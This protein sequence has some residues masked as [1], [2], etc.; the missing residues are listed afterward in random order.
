VNTV[1]IPDDQDDILLQLG[2]DVQILIQESAALLAHLHVEDG[3]HH[4]FQLPYDL[5]GAK[6]YFLSRCLM[7]VQ[8][9]AGVLIR[10]TEHLHEEGER[11]DRTTP[12]TSTTSWSPR[13]R[14]ADARQ[15]TSVKISG[16]RVG[17]LF[18]V[19][20]TCERKSQP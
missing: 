15:R 4:H 10:L 17:H 7:D 5:P 19:Q 12:T 14:R 11:A 8:A 1:N 20:K 9:V 3:E 13:Q 16:L 18:I 6:A 2:R